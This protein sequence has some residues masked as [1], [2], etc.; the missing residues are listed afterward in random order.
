MWEQQ[1]W[2]GPEKKELFGNVKGEAVWET[3]E[4]SPPGVEDSPQ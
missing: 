2:S 3:G 1:T 4:G